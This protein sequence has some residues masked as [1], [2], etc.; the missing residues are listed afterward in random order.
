MT[1]RHNAAAH[2]YEMDTDS[3][4]AIAVYREQGDRMIFTHTEVPPADEGKGFAS[5]LVGAALGRCAQARLQDRAGLQLRRRL[6][7]PA[8]RVRR[9][10]RGARAGP[11]MLM[12][13]GGQNRGPD[14]PRLRI[15]LARIAKNAA[16]HA[17]A[18]TTAAPG[19][20]DQAHRHGPAAQR[21][22]VGEVVGGVD[23]EAEQRAVQRRRKP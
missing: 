11:L 3:G 21:G 16:T 14:G 9:S 20:I 23:D 7:A 8:S 2:R 1:V 10:A 13:G 17:A 19:E 6:R 15:K 22:E 5:R 12:G 18:L 4:L